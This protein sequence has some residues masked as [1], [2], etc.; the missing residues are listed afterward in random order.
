MYNHIC[1]G[2][3]YIMPQ[4]FHYWN[5]IFYIYSTN[6]ILWFSSMRLWWT[7]VSCSVFKAKKEQLWHHFELI[8]PG[9]RPE[10]TERDCWI[11]LRLCI[12]ITGYLSSCYKKLRH[13]MWR[14]TDAV[15]ICFWDDEYDLLCHHPWFT[16]LPLSKTL[17]V[18]K[19]ELEVTMKFHSTITPKEYSLT[20]F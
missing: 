16:N 9:T 20:G 6:N 4:H 3:L 15:F 11:C 17:I 7:R 10:A 13:A 14:L 19:L 2:L 1:L 8:C 18:K 5:V 12:S